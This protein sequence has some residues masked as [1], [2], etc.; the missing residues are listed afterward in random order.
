MQTATLLKLS[1]ALLPLGYRV[2][3]EDGL[4]DVSVYDADALVWCV[5]VK[6]KARDLETLH[7]RLLE[8]ADAVDEAAPDRGDDP[9]RKAKYL[10]RKRATYFSL[11]AVGARLHFGVTYPG[12]SSFV[13]TPD[14]VPL[15]A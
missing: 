10:I 6:E 11:V 1:Q 4:M 14:M 13:L 7:R 3:F 9:L 15:P 8:Y 12:D 2:N 5:E